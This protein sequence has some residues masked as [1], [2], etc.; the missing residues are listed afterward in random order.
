VG[1]KYYNKQQTANADCKQFDE[2][3]EHN[4]S[5]CTVL[6]KEQYIKRHV[7]VL[8]CAVTY[9]RKWGNETVNTGVAM[10]RMWYKQVTKLWWPYCGRKSANQQNYS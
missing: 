8:N 1:Q 10:Y 4:I 2:M 9:A 6:A 7:S 5:A 3:V